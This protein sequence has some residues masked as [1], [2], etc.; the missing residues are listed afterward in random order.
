MTQYDPGLFEPTDSGVQLAT[1]LNG[2]VGSLHTNHKGPARPAYVRPGMLWIDDAGAAWLLK[3]FDG[4]EDITI[5]GI[6]PATHQLQ[7]AGVPATRKV[8]TGAAFLLNGVAG[9]DAAPA[10]A[11]L[12]ADLLI[13][14]IFASTAASIEG[15]REDLPVHPAGMKAAIDGALAGFSAGGIKGVQVFKESR[16]Y[17]P[18]DGATKALVIATGGG[19]S[20]STGSTNNYGG[21]AGG[22]GATAIALVDAE[23]ATVTIGA[24]GANRGTAANLLGTN[25]GDTSFGSIV[26]GGAP[27]C[28]SG[29]AGGQGGNTGANA[30]VL[31]PG[32]AGSHGQY[33]ASQGY[34]GNGGASFWGG[35]GR[36]G[37]AGTS[38]NAGAAPGSGGG[39]G[40]QLSS[41]GAGANGIVLVLEF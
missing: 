24:G 19:A 31:L 30:D 17:N 20:G 40:P 36:G 35:G 38:G 5:A 4:E 33:V 11:D 13:K 22:A 37:V 18:T 9:T 3:L 7:T 23:V 1:D 34:S 8:K 39:G 27:A 16:T 12:S 26:A 10:E 2:L 25:G 29:Y 21:G 6:N 28:T 32:G 15:T 41:S 14:L